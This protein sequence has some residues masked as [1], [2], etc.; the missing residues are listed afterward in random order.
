MNKRRKTGL[1]SRAVPPRSE[2]E[3]RRRFPPL[4]LLLLQGSSLSPCCRE[5]SPGIAAGV[6]TKGREASGERPNSQIHALPAKKSAGKSMKRKRGRDVK[7][8]CRAEWQNGGSL[9]AT[10]SLNAFQCSWGPRCPGYTYRLPVHLSL[11]F[12]HGGIISMENR[13]LRLPL[14]AAV[15]SGIFFQSANSG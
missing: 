3:G 14:S 11:L 2:A 13:G 4:F 9:C 1:P 6:S 12:C 10:T 5:G 15:L 8:T 7:K